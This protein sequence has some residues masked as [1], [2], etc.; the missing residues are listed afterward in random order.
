MWFGQ[1]KLIEERAGGKVPL[2]CF[3][4]YIFRYSAD[5]FTAVFHITHTVVKSQLQS[6]SS[7]YEAR[8]KS[9]TT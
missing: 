6:L 7:S 9:S 5:G 2:Q 3:I 8:A 1:N 4:I